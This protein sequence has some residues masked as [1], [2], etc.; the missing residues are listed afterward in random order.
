MTLGPALPAPLGVEGR[1]VVN[2]PDRRSG[3]TI[4]VAGSLDTELDPDRIHAAVPLASARLVRGEWVGGRP[5]PVVTVAGDPLETSDAWRPIDLATEAP[6]RVLVGA[7]KRVALAA[8]HAAFDGLSVLTLLRLL[9]GAS[10]ARLEEMGVEPRPPSPRDGGDRGWRRLLRPTDRVA[11]S[12]TEPTREAMVWRTVAL[13]GAGVTARLAGAVAAAVG[14]HNRARGAVWRRAG[15]SIGLGG[16]PG[17]GN[18]ASYRRVDID[19]DGGTD[20]AAAVTAVVAS[21]GPPPAELRRAPRA[22]RL[23]APVVARLGD[24]FL[25][26]NL[27]RH[28]LE[29]LTDVAFFPVARGPSAVAVGAVAG[30]NGVGT[31]AL[32]ARHLDADDARA[33]LDGAVERLTPNMTA[34]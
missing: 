16:P 34:P 15:I 11:R 29:G 7:D 17:M 23:L 19:V 4:V 24:S 18:R 3:W 13:A 8:H 6:L 5:N 30:G 9:A 22:L 10:P 33:V 1:A 32:R 20:V 21:G 27:G 2:H 14:D 26:S 25:V 28:D 12:A 31:V